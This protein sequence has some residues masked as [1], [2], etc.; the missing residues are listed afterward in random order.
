MVVNECLN[1]YLLGSFPSNF[2]SEISLD[3]ILGICETRCILQAL[4]DHFVI[5]NVAKALVDHFVKEDVP[6][7]VK[8]FKFVETY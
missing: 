7:I 1:K 6:V 8:N 2:S 4:F 5:D 3:K